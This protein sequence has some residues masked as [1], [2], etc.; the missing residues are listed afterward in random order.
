LNYDWD[1][2]VLPLL[3]I[4]IT[5]SQP[6]S[7]S[8]YSAG[9]S[10]GCSDATAG[11][12]PYLNSPGKGSAF[13]T[14]N[15]MQGYNDGYGACSH[16]SSGRGSNTGPNIPIQRAIPKFAQVRSNLKPNTS[17]QKPASSAQTIITKTFNLN[18]DGIIFPIR[19]AITGNGNGVYNI[20]WE[21]QSRDTIAVSIGSRSDGKLIIEMPRKLLLGSPVVFI[22]GAS[23]S[24]EETTSNSKV[25]TLEID[26]SKDSNQIEIQDTISTPTLN[27]RAIQQA[28]ASNNQNSGGQGIATPST[29]SAVPFL[30]T[31][32][33]QQT[34]SQQEPSSSP[35][36]GIITKTFSVGLFPIRYAITGNGNVLHTISWK[37]RNTLSINIGSKSDGNLIIELPREL[38]DSPQVFVDGIHVPAKQTTINSKVRT[39]VVNFHKDSSKIEMQNTSSSKLL[40]SFRPHPPPIPSVQP[41]T[42]LP[43]TMGHSINNQNPTNTGIDYVSLCTKLQPVLVQSCHTF[44]NTNGSLTSQGNHALHCVKSAILLSGDSSSWVGVPLSTVLNGLSMLA[45]PTGCDRVVN[46]GGFSQLGN[47]GSLNSIVRALP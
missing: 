1:S 13:H 30:L 5:S 15:F 24:V 47:I 17:I 36:Q 22:D 44:V 32:S 39:L 23:T 2:A 10:H 7:A 26:F 45:P 16:S 31:P 12:H 14:A 46:M 8:P 34:Q 42:S 29:N 37:N 43:S 18:R 9:Y 40:P 21:Q 28:E 38:I 41:S 19:Y 35:T 20:A 33:K 3:I 11:G 6:A 4:I 27:A 25:R